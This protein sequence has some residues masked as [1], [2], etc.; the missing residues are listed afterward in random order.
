MDGVQ[1][2]HKSKVAFRLSIIIRDENPGNLTITEFCLRLLVIFSLQIV[3][4]G[5]ILTREQVKEKKVN[6]EM[7]RYYE[8]NNYQNL[9]E[10]INYRNNK[11]KVS[12]VNQIFN[13]IH[14]GIKELAKLLR[15]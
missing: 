9:R 4:N 3:I 12:F 10:Y 7:D 8:A 1:L 6:S 14:E 2:N 13:N 11:L 15:F 5:V